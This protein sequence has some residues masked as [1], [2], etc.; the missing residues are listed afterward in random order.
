MEKE[1]S[2]CHQFLP[3]SEFYIRRD[4][5][6]PI[7]RCKKC[8]KNASKISWS[9]LSEKEKKERY[10]KDGIWYEEQ[11]RNGNIKVILRHKLN[12]YK[13]NA[14]R[15]QVPFNL[16]VKYLI[17][18]FEGQQGLCYYTGE[19]LTVTSGKGL[20]KTNFINVPNQFSLDRLIPDKGYVEG[21]VVWCSWLVNTMKN[22]LTEEQFYIICKNILKYKN[23]NIEK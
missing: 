13:G 21:N 18:L 1:C 22:Y 14:K 10:R 5:M 3:L 12:S 2:V 6:K 23:F 11:A 4:R 17:D 20:G 16:S 7:S 8:N 9:K 15:K 19:K